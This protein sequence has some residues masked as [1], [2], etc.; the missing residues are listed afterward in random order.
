MAR[1]CREKGISFSKQ[2]ITSLI[3][4]FSPR[5]FV[6]NIFEIEAGYSLPMDKA[7]LVE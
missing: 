5:V 3:V 2:E 7:K 4:Y 1:G 6:N